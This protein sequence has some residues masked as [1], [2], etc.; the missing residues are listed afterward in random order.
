M[1]KQ[2][3]YKM[4]GRLMWSLIAV[5]CVFLLFVSMRQKVQHNCKHVIVKIKA[6]E[7]K[8]FLDEED[9]ENILVHAT[10]T[11]RKLSGQ[12]LAGINMAAM[13]RR[14]MEEEWISDVNVFVDNQQNL[15]VEVWERVPV[16]RVFDIQ[17]KS[18]YLDSAATQ[19]PLSDN[20]RAGLPVF[21]NVPVA[22][23]DS[24]YGLQVQRQIVKL[25]K[26]IQ[27]DAFWRAQAAQIDITPGGGFEIYPAIGSQVI[28]LGKAEE[29]EEK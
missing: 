10:G 12:P 25:A 20:E 2:Q 5:A 16:A 29:L 3:T 8:I 7:G 18:Y 9:V 14:L 19:L 28:E 4:L 6:D 27:R 26:I 11:S 17:G 15:V 23:G 22:K 13:E 24:S 21:T 1:S